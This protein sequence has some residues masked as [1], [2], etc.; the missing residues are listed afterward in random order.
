MHVFDL[1]ALGGGSC[2][3]LLFALIQLLLPFLTD[4]IG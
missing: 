1:L 2:W 4:V 3:A